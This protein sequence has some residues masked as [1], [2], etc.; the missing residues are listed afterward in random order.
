MFNHADAVY[1]SI[2][3]GL[4]H[5]LRIRSSS[6]Y[7]IDVEFLCVCPVI[8]H[9]FRHNMVKVP[10]D[11]RDDSRGST[12]YFAIDNVMTKFIFNNRIGA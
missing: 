11:P 5:D 6:I 3:Y 2:N 8:D 12:D 9:A 10:V 7:Q 4:E 1:R